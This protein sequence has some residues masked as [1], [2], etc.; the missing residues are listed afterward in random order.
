MQLWSHIFPSVNNIT[1]KQAQDKAMYQLGSS[2]KRLVA[3]MADADNTLFAFAKLDIKDGFW[4]LVVHPDDVWNFCYVLPQASDVPEDNI[5]LI[6]LTALQRGWCKSPPFFCMALETASDVIQHLLNNDIVLPAH[7]FEECMLSLTQLQHWKLPNPQHLLEV[8]VDNFIVTTNDTSMS[9][10]LAISQAFLHGIHCVFPPTN[11]TGH[12]GQDPISEKKL[13]NGD[14]LWEYIKK[15]LGW[16]LN[17]KA[18]TIH[19]LQKKALKT[20]TSLKVIARKTQIT[21]H[22][23][24]VIC[25]KLQHAAFGISGG[26]GLFSPL[27]QAMVGNPLIIVITPFL[28]ET[29]QDWSTTVK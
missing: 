21:L 12:N 22:T 23:F 17:G 16:E 4:H 9:N 19:L 6:V 27:Q 20:F 7:N 26:M 1:N 10:L 15:V 29:L 18:K 24:Q 14:G 5:L 25:G 3:T 13:D 8:F 11:V 2:L 28:H